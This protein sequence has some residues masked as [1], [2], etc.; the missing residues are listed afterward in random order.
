MLA[1]VTVI[2]EWSLKFYASI[3]ATSTSSAKED[4]AVIRLDPLTDPEKTNGVKM[5]LAL[6]AKSILQQFPNLEVIKTNLQEFLDMVQ[7]WSYG[8]GLLDCCDCIIFFFFILCYCS[9]FLF[10][11]LLSNDFLVL[12]DSFPLLL[13]LVK[14]IMR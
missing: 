4:R 7:K 9:T 2:E 8:C 1:R 10:L 3:S 6:L 14:Q 13:D 12:C 11:Q 5:A